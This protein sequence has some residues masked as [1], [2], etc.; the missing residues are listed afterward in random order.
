MSPKIVD[1]PENED[2][3][4]KKVSDLQEN[5]TVKDRVFYGK[6]KKVTGWTEFNPGKEDEQNGHY[7]AMKI[8]TDDPTATVNFELVG[9]TGKSTGTLDEDR[10]LILRIQDKNKQSLKLKITNDTE[11]TEVTEY[12]FYGLT[13]S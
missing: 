1:V 10:I 11:E 12:K 6:L 5:I 3:L 9:G 4:S 13:L 2:L 7:L 8:E